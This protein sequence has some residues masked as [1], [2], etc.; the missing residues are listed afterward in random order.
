M[1]RLL[2]IFP[3]PPVSWTYRVLPGESAAAGAAERTNRT[4]VTVMDA[5]IRKPLFISPPFFLASPSFMFPAAAPIADGR[6]FSL[7]G[8]PRGG[9]PGQDLVEILNGHVQEFHVV[10]LNVKS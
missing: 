10:C 8:R 1:R 5:K 6:F 7:L 3:Q 2:A 4:I 9:I